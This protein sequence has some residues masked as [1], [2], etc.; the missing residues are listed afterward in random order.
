MNHVIFRHSTPIQVR[1]TDI[2]MM[3]HV[4]NSMYLA[5][6]DIAR[7]D[8]FIRVL[9]QLIEH[10]EESLVIASITIDYLQPIFFHEKIE[11]RTKTTKIGNKS[12]HTLQHIIN[13]ETKEIKAAVKAVISGFDYIGQKTIVVPEK[14]KKSLAEFDPDVEFKNKN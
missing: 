7:M 10:K 5:Y 12:I 4:T 14:W 2:D 11:I 8:Y 1:Y 6:C 3:A 9:E 13:S